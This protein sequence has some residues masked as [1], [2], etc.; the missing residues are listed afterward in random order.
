MKR[1]ALNTS[2]LALAL[3]LTAQLA[4]SPAFS[5]QDSRSAPAATTQA[6]SPDLI[7]DADG[8]LSQ[9]QMQELFR[10]VADKDM[11]NDKLLRNYT[12]VER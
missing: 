6:S 2:Q 4:A 3:A 9:A 10:V 5:Q 11:Q 7:P 8:K 1:L 12:Y